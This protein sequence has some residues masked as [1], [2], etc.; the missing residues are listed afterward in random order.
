M[1]KFKKAQGVVIFM[2]IYRN[3]DRTLVKATPQKLVSEIPVYF[4]HTNPNINLS[5]RLITTYLL[6][7]SQLWQI[8]SL[9]SLFW[10][11]M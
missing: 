8:L 6:T 5:I 10:V 9:K 3:L 1:Y 2:Y 4:N 7:K 11:K